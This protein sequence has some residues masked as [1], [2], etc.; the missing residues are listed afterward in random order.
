M[1]P[2]FSFY[3]TANTRD[4]SVSKETEINS[5]HPEPTTRSKN[6]PETGI[7]KP[8]VEFE[9]IIASS[10][11]VKSQD[12]DS[13]FVSAQTTQQVHFLCP[14]KRGDEVTVKDE[15]RE[16]YDGSFVSESDP[17]QSSPLLYNGECLSMVL[18]NEHVET[19]GHVQE[20]DTMSEVAPTVSTRINNKGLAYI[21]DLCGKALSSEKSLNAHYTVHTADRSH[22]CIQCGKQ[23][24]N[25]TNLVV[26]QNI[27]NMHNKNK[28]PSNYRPKCKYI[29]SICGKRFLTIQELNCHLAT[30]S[31]EK[32]FSCM[33]CGKKFA[34]QHILKIHQ[35]THTGA[36]PFTCPT[37][38]MLFADPSHLD[39]H[40]RM[41][42][43]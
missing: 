13:G 34:Q 18:H 33:W 29:C 11:E 1:I 27:H 16:W 40:N 2:F 22:E 12:S 25:R 5:K 7:Q 23:F 17:Q 32:S 42:R 36:K 31:G 10:V 3:F 41:H 30:H 19:S 6:K 35:N 26:H 8:Y 43:Q 14:N 15:E 4:A 21:C 20:H 24:V 38:Q 37:Y 28:R 39:K 9:G